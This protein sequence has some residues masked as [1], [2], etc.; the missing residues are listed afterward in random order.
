MTE[1]QRK[2]LTEYLGEC[3]HEYDKSSSL[4]NRCTCGAIC[5]NLAEHIN[6]STHTFTTIQDKQDL[7][8]KVIAKGDEDSFYSF[9]KDLFCE[10]YQNYNENTDEFGFITH[11]IQLSPLETAELVLK[12]KMV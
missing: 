10:E 8:E 5:G 9:V 3:W 4:Y 12:W 6:E 1:S 11:F 7:L 2:W